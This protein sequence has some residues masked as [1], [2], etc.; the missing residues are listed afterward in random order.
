MIFP[1]YSVL[2]LPLVGDLPG[3]FHAAPTES[4]LRPCL[5][6]SSGA[7]IH[8]SFYLGT[9]LCTGLYAADGNLQM[10]LS[11]QIRGA[12]GGKKSPRCKAEKRVRFAADVV[13]NEGAPRPARS[14][15]TEERVPANREALYRGM[16]Y[17][18]SAHRATCAPADLHAG[19]P[20]LLCP[21]LPIF[22]YVCG[23]AC[24]S[25]E[26]LLCT[27]AAVIFWKKG[28]PNSISFQTRRVMVGRR[29]LLSAPTRTV[30]RTA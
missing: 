28:N 22:L 16:L 2:D 4:V 30:D 6:S 29:R 25:E 17:D 9:S 11:T 3:S 23:F 15:P 24:L 14:S 21:G 12:R 13:D 8:P 19:S 20:A 10:A 1:F 26:A 18:R 7:F 27:Y 5:S